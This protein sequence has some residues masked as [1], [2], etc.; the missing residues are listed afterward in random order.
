M[1]RYKKPQ[2]YVVNNSSI[3]KK[4]GEKYIVSEGDL[5]LIK[6]IE[7]GTGE[8]DRFVNL[9]YNPI[10]NPHE[11]EVRIIDMQEKQEEIL[12]HKDENPNG[13]ILFKVS[14]PKTH[15]D[16][17][18]LVASI[19]RNKTDENNLTIFFAG[20]NFVED[21]QIVKVEGQHRYS[22]LRDE[23]HG[24]NDLLRAYTKKKQGK[25][26]QNGDH[27]LSD[28]IGKYAVEYKVI[29]ELPKKYDRES[30]TSIEN[31]NYI[32]LLTNQNGEVVSYLGFDSETG[33]E[34]ALPVCKNKEQLV[35]ELL[36][37][38]LPEIIP[39]MFPE[40]QEFAWINSTY[41]KSKEILQLEES[42]EEVKK[43]YQERIKT[44]EDQIQQVK[45][46][47][48]FLT[49]L[50]TESGDK[51]VAAVVKYLEWLGFS[52]VV[53]ADEKE[54]GVLREDI[55]IVLEKFLF[56][57]EVKGIGG[58]STD[59]EC[60]QI[61]KHRRRREKEHRDKEI[62]PIYIVNH[63]RYM[64]PRQR[65]IPPFSED[66]IDYAQNDERGLLTTWDMY[67]KYKLIESAIFT[68]K[69]VREAFHKQ[70][71]LDLTPTDIQMVGKVSE[72]YQEPRAC[73]LELDGV[74][75]SVGDEIIC[76]KDDTWLRGKIESLKV[77]DNSIESAQNGEIGLVLDIELG[78]G[79]ILYKR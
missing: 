14:F 52:N 51:L 78:K 67:N 9:D 46:E 18:P 21:Y 7:Y 13:E 64:D 59:S 75:V 20:S 66:Q 69:E 37:Q 42:I 5:G 48:M 57:I 26:I 29:Y 33:Y 70:G 55:Q 65:S 8:N 17:R 62:I 39:K 73:I 61:G 63:Q 71:L 24:S 19:I 43:K 11:Y 10:P 76:N 50:L 60:A 35:E 16:P 53:L 45:E 32:P 79:Y 47:N 72:Y 54:S 68:K 49:E 1:D 4:I 41:Y 40:S 6:K 34:L 31:E 30:G 74:R 15:F 22:Y 27:K 44:I 77:N 28:I 2:V 56:I 25:K 36:S 58:T 3:A 12:S 38:G 23:K